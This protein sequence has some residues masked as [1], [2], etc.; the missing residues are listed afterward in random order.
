VATS[1]P[2]QKPDPRP[3][4]PWEAWK[5]KP[6]AIEELCEHVTAG[7]HAAGFCGERG[8]SYTTLLGW[9]AVKGSGR[10]E[11]YAHARAERADKLADEIVAISDEV[12]VIA[13]HEGE[14]VRLAMDAAAIA[15]NRLRV[16]ARKWVASKLKPK[17][18]GDKLE[19]GGDKDNPL[20][21]F[22]QKLT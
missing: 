13:T 3:Q 4:T 22:I 2:S 6:D 20:Q 1:K 12:E 10:A 19:L 18:Y 21:V 5:V 16:D 7:G 17:S 11:L 9:L 14:T 15:R 8:I